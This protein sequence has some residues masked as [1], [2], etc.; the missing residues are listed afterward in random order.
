MKSLRKFWAALMILCMCAPVFAQ[1]A[2][3]TLQIQQDENGVYQIGTAQ[4]L[5]DFAAIL[6]GD[7]VTKDENA[8]AVITADID[9][10]ENFRQIGGNIRGIIDGQGHTITVDIRA[11]EDKRGSLFNFLYGTIKIWW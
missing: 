2:E 10:T 7:G 1:D 9:Y 11:T 3:G 4:D 6:A 5:R 8:N